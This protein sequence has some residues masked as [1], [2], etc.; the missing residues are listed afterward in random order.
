MPLL[1]KIINSI[2]AQRE[3]DQQAELMQKLMRHEAK[4]GGELFGPVAGNR[5]REFFC[6]DKHSWVWHEQWTD[7]QGKKHV[8]NTRYEVRPDAILK[9]QN[10]GQYQKVS[11]AE[12]H[13][14]AQ[15]ADVY[16]DRIQKEVYNFV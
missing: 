13:R 16:Y 3:L 8:V 2:A 9:S 5:K 7:E 15:A 12:I 4:I 1:K 10:G 14:L 6:L 11:A